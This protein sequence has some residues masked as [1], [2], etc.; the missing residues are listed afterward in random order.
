MP[1]LY[2]MASGLQQDWKDGS[3]HRYHIVQHFVD[4]LLE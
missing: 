2:S 4:N 1:D 3:L